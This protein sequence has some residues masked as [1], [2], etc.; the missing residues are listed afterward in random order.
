MCRSITQRQRSLIRSYKT[1]ASLPLEIPIDEE[2][3]PNYDPRTFFHPN[4][5]DI[6][7]HR[8]TLKAKIGWGTSS[9]VWLAQDTGG[10][11]SRYVAIKINGCKYASRKAARHELKVSHHIAGSELCHRGRSIVRT[12][13]DSFEVASPNGSHL[14]LVFD[15]MREPLWLFRRR[16]GA[17]KV[18][19]PF[20]PITKAYLYLK[21][22]NILVTFED[23]S[24]IDSFVHGQLENLMSRKV[25][26]GRT[27]W[28]LLA[29][30][31]LFQD[32]QDGKNHKYSAQHHLG[33]M[34]DLLG[35]VP[36]VLIERERNMRHWRWS[37]E[38]RNPEGKL[39]NNA[40]DFFGGPFFTKERE[41]MGHDLIAARN[42][43]DIAPECVIN[44]DKTL[45]LSFMKRMLCWLPE[46]RA[47][48]K[49]LKEHP[50]LD[51]TRNGGS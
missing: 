45:F 1:P 27:V 30:Q 8:Y 13:V 39:C 43:A 19:Q 25:L 32:H 12:A 16:F 46:D 7:D 6:L 3:I 48:A 35:P 36:K 37:P 11:S 49:E 20:L 15:P 31:Q 24:V 51:F 21:L 9:T 33:E 26:S 29:G 14:C 4:V 10:L 40:A 38:A 47:I 5:G 28:D 41:F 34:I 18:T 42:L 23:P 50:W 22:D 44:D 17:D 2:T